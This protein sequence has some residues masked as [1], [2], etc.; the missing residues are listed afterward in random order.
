[1]QITCSEENSCQI[2]TKDAT[3]ILDG[4]SVKVNGKTLPGSGEYE[5]G[6]VFFEITLKVTHFHAEELVSAVLNL[7]QKKLDEN[8][9]EKMEGLDLVLIW[10][11]NAQIETQKKIADLISQ[12]DPQVVVLVGKGDSLDIGGKK[13]ELSENIK[14]TKPTLPVG[15]RLMYLISPK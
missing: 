1:M 9:L 10:F 14:V 15:E 7:N 11:D 6:K 13:P 3:I 8:D 2:K 5:I 4:Q 12:I